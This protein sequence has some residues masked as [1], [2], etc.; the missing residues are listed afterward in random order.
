MPS[1]EPTSLFDMIFKAWAALVP[2]A[3]CSVIV[4]AVTLERIWMFSHLR[5]MSVD[6]RQRVKELLIFGQHDAAAA[7]LAAENNAHARMAATVLQRPNANAEEV[8]DTLALAAD[9]ELM[10]AGAPVPILGTIGN[11]APFI[12]LFGTVIGIIKS[13]EAIHTKGV[14]GYETVAPGIAEALVATAGGL[15]VGI[16]AVIANNWCSAWLERYRLSLERFATEWLYV[17]DDIRNGK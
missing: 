7:L 1:T 3:L 4:V 14:T 13:F 15:A 9:K 5:A 6:I 11:I 16:I 12:G 8:A 2:L 10:D 17:L